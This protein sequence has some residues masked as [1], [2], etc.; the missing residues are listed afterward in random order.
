MRHSR[1]RA[2]R[3]S[4]LSSSVVGD[5]T[6]ANCALGSGF[7]GGGRSTAVDDDDV[8]MQHGVIGEWRGDVVRTTITT[9]ASSLSPFK[10][11][12]RLL[13]FVV[14]TGFDLQSLARATGVAKERGSGTLNAL[15]R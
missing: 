10:L 15:A 4:L 7:C 8:G 11:E 13:Q 1:S 3:P 2:I 5:R 9:G 12:I 6:I 14:V